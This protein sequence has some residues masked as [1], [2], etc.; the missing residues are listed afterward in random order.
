MNLQG[1]APN[2]PSWWF[3][4]ALR[5]EGV[6]PAAPALTGVLTVDV[7]I[8]GGGYTGLW[9]AL[10]LKERAPH[11]VVALIESSQCGSGASGKNGGKVS[12]YWPSLTGIAAN[13]GPDA[14]LAVAR[15]GTRAQDAIRLFATEPGRDVWWR[16][17][18]HMRVSAAPAQDAQIATYLDTARQLGV[19]D[20]VRSLTAEEVQ[21]IC[22]SPVFRDGIYFPEGATVQPARLARQLRAA[23]IAADV[24]VFEG[25]P[26]IRL[27]EGTLN[28]VVTPTGEIIAKEV[29]LA[30]NIELAKRRE[31]V[32]FLTVFSSYALVT[33]PAPEK[34]SLMGWKRE[35]GITDLRMFVH[36]FRKIIDGR[37][38]MGSGSGPIGFGGHTSDPRL[39]TDM[40][41]AVRAERGLRRLLPAFGD[42]QIDRTWGGGIDISFDRLPFFRTLSGTRIHYACGYSGHGVNPTYIGGQ[43]LASLVLRSKD[44]WSSLPFCTREPRAL[45]PEPFRYVGGRFVRWGI[46]RCEEDEEVGKRSR[47]LPRVAAA[48]PKTFGLRIGTR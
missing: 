42:V 1:K 25:T 10:A 34:I 21:E 9:T 36:Y 37:V 48:I 41:S 6:Q 39:T 28:R 29:V 45:P 3:E 22:R 24:K 12:G 40:A 8:V 35:E 4:E 26:M 15:A 13:I 5:S 14:A 11:L 38:L 47:L 17:N 18:G 46:L 32:P 2:D 30:T 23:A 27:D 7:V 43:C 16:E 44:E 33:Q 19:A 31:I 20:T